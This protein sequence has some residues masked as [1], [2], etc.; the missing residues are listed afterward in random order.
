MQWGTN[1]SERK[2]RVARKAIDQLVNKVALVGDA[3]HGFYGFTNHPNLGETAVT[4]D[5]TNPATTGQQILDD[6]LAMYDAVQIQSFDNHIPN[7]L[8]LAPT[9]RSA[10]MRKNVNEGGNWESV[11]ARFRSLYPGVN[12]IA[13]TELEPSAANGNESTAVMYERDVDNMKHRDSAPVRAA[14]CREAQPRNGDRLYR[15][16]LRRGYLPPAVTH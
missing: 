10:L 9:R 14:A 7:T 12:I 15:Q 11:M 8:A 4:G 13:S 2:G 6:L 16:M 3:A 1:L 5:W